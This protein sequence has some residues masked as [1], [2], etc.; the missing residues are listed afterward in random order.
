MLHKFQH[1]GIKEAS[2]PY[3]YAFKLTENSG[4]VAQLEYASAIGSLMYAMHCTRPNISFVA[5]KFSRYTIN[6]STEHWKEIGRVPGFFKRTIELGLYYTKF[7]LV[8]E[9]YTD[10]SWI[11]SASDNKATSGWV[12][13]LGGGAVSWASKKQTCISHST[14]ES[15]FIA[16]VEAGKDA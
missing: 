9:G 7:S 1:L 2:T 8:L 6:P 13:T 4:A 10:G 16:L 15:E 14:M 11:T 5:C 3:D 12:F